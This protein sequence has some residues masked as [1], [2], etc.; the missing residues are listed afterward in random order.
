MNKEYSDINK[1][2]INS[3]IT[4]TDLNGFTCGYYAPQAVLLDKYYRAPHIKDKAQMPKNAQ[5]DII[6]ILNNKHEYNIQVTVDYLTIE[7]EDSAPQAQH[8]ALCHVI[9]K[10]LGYSSWSYPSTILYNDCVKP[11]QPIM[12]D[13]PIP[14]EGYYI[15]CDGANDISSTVNKSSYWDEFVKKNT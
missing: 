1:S 3:N 9:I 2:N 11:G 6:D 5:R 10:S 4:T 7:V 13:T 12:T 15:T 14:R 8:Q